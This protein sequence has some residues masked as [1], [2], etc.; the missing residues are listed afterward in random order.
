MFARARRSG[1]GDVR[2]ATGGFSP[3]DVCGRAGLPRSVVLRVTDADDDDCGRRAE[4]PG[5]GAS[6]WAH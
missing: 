4:P 3:D 6:R 5:K 2:Q 1:G